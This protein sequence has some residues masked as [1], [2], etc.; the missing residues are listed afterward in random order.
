M[1]MYCVR[2]EL[3]IA[4]AAAAS[5]LPTASTA[6]GDGTAEL[7]GTT[8]FGGVRAWVNSWD[9]PLGDSMLVI[10][11][12]TA[13]SPVLKIVPTSRQSNTE[14][15]AIPYVGIKAGNVSV[16][17]AHQFETKYSVS[18]ASNGIKRKETDITFGY[19]VLPGLTASVGVKEARISQTDTDNLA[20]SE[21]QKPAK[22]QVLLFGISGSAPLSTVWGIYGNVAY[23]P[24]R[25]KI[26][27]GALGNKFNGDYKIGEFGLSY[28]I[29]LGAG[30]TVKSLTAT[31]G[32]RS[33]VVKAR[34]LP[35]P[36]YDLST[37]TPVLQSLN[38]SAQTSTTQGLVFGMVGAF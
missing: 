22:V 38:P 29:P 5:L 3:W 36:A 32:Y 17:L 4:I 26:D 33:Q 34:N 1:E 7:S 12:P 13:R 10:P 30:S 31:L 25:T 24:S 15:S 6:A 27:Y 37:G 2:R 35:F 8:W 19:A 18:D 9:V 28:R 16:S 11:S 20:Q 14:I 23:G 21:G